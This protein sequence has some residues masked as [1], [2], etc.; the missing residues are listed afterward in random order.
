MARGLWGGPEIPRHR[1]ST[2]ERRLVDAATGLGVEVGLTAGSSAARVRGSRVLVGRNR[3]GVGAAVQV[4]AGEADWSYP[5]LLAVTAGEV[6]I[7]DSVRGRWLASL[8]P[9]PPETGDA[10]GL[11]VDRFA[12]GSGSPP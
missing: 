9:T 8:A 7:P 10:P 11:G 2:D 1:L 3:V 5:A 12:G 4:M 6:E